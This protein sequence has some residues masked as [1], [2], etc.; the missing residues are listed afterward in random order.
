MNIQREDRGGWTDRRMVRWSRDI[1]ASSFIGR[2][3][4]KSNETHAYP[5]IAQTS[6]AD[7]DSQCEMQ[8]GM[9]L[10]ISA[11]YTSRRP[12]ATSPFLWLNLTGKEIEVI[13]RSRLLLRENHS[14][15]DLSH[16]LRKWKRNHHCLKSLLTTVS[17]VLPPRTVHDPVADVAGRHAPSLAAVQGRLGGEGS[18]DRGS[19]DYLA[20][21]GGGRDGGSRHRGG[22]TGV[23]L[24][25]SDLVAVV[26]AVQVT[27]A[28]PIERNAPCAVALKA[29]GAYCINELQTES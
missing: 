23:A 13:L 4:I 27:V 17:L 1:R 6:C 8:A 25:A 22:R 21:R 9:N 7:V 16:S 5:S 29:T 10:P 20:E 15:R 11:W 26:G 2:N 28:S 14:T 18:L 19:L 12:S 3:R 24:A